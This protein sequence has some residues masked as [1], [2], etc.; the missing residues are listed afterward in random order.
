MQ[1]TQIQLKQQNT[2]QDIIFDAI[3]SFL[4]WTRISQLR[5]ILVICQPNKSSVI[6][7]KLLVPETVIK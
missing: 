5:V 7:H 6:I 1:V 3:W 2:E 4:F